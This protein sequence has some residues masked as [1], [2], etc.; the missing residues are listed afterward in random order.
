M[1]KK[2][3]I[4]GQL[5]PDGR[6]ELVKQWLAAAIL[7]IFVVGLGQPARA[8]GSIQINSVQPG[9]V[10]SLADRIACQTAI[11][12]IYWQHRIWPAENPGERPPFEKVVPAAAIEAKVMNSLTL[13]NGLAEMWQRPI[14]AEMLQA[15]VERQAEASQQ[16]EMLQEIWAALGNDPV[17]VAECLA[18]PVLATRLA[19]NWFAADERFSGRTFQAWWAASK[20][21]FVPE[22]TV[23]AGAYQLPAINRGRELLEDDTWRSTTATPDEQTG[24]AVWTGTEMLHLGN[25]STQGFRYNPATDTWDTMTTINA[26]NNVYQFTAVWT[27]TEMITWGGCN[28]GTEFCTTSLGGRYNPATDSWTETQFNGAPVGRRRHGAVWTGTEMIVW[29]GCRENSNGNQN[30]SIVLNNG[31][32]YN[33]N[34][35]SWQLMTTANAPAART[36]P[37]L[38][39]TDDEMILWSGTTF[40]ATAGSRY[41]PSTDSW[42]TMSTANAPSGR[43]APLVWTGSEV[44]AWGGCT[45][46]PFCDTAVGDGG[47]YNPDSDSWTPMSSSNAP[48]PRQEHGAVWTGSEM[49]VWGGNN[50]TTYYN[51]G[52]RYNPANDSWTTISTTNAPLGRAS[53]QY[54]WTGSELLV[55][56]GFGQ[57]SPALLRSGG[58]YNPSTNSWVAVRNEDPF[59]ARTLHRAIWTGVEMIAWGGYG[60]GTAASGLNTGRIYDPVTDSWDETSTANAPFG[61]AGHTAIWTGTEMIVWGGNTQSWSLPGDGGRYNPAT[62]SWTATSETNAPEAPS[63]HSAVWTGTEMIVWGGN[64][65][66]NPFDNEGGRY[67]PT[68]NSWTAMSDSNEPEGRYLHTAVWTGNVMVVWGGAGSTGT[69]GDGGVYNPTTNSWTAVSNT[70]APVDRV[71]HTAVWTGTEMII[72]GGSENYNEWPILNSG[73][74]YNPATNSWTPT[75]TAD[76]PTP[77]ARHTAVWTGDEMIVWG[78]CQPGDDCY[79]TTNTGGRYDPQ[80][81][82]WMLTTLEHVP[83]GRYFHTAVWTGNEMIVWGG[84]TED[85]GYA[86]TGGRYYAE[87]SGNNAPQANND[88]YGVVADGELVVNAPGVLANDSDLDSDPLTVALVEGPANGTLVLNGNGSFSYT[89]DAGYIGADS[90]SYQA[91]DGSMM[92]NVASVG[93]TVDGENSGPTATADVYMTNEDVPLVVAAPGVLANDQDVDGDG[94][95]AE[96][97]GNPAHGTVTLNGDGSFTY[98][99]DA[100]YH[101]ADSFTYQASDGII[102]SNVA[103]VS[104]TVNS[105]NDAPVAGNDGYTVAAGSTLDIGA[106]GVLGNDSDAE[107]NSLTVSLQSAPAHGEVT[108]NGNGSFSYTADDGYSGSDSF[109]YLVSDGQGGS[110]TATVTILVGVNHTIYLPMVV[111]P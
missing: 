3:R 17:L 110:D 87:T 27:G 6:L 30:C 11:E 47:R 63:Y 33:P 111:R 22:L 60:D 71:L 19:Q 5:L 49:I 9:Q 70:N 81:D 100:N 78:G 88:S 84:E 86:H 82:S 58:R 74:R 103:T 10:L 40:G 42:Q 92:S 66:D 36:Y 45:G 54:F 76:A 28:G 77:A 26:P 37:E 90:F 89:P 7:L 41:N 16:P 107:G 106:P 53:H 64:T 93:I 91:S 1:E 2:A 21:Q 72:W 62:D 68:T 34:T 56:G 31:G 25:F 38:I 102:E 67:N 52:R 104:L 20:E 44:I 12:R 75:N 39:W 59:S 24:E 23:P 98:T 79:D 94:L 108:L 99:P 35:D 97:V 48:S 8:A 105:M 43:Q 15:E 55:W 13:S 69:L 73:G 50:G 96:L 85:N 65:Y 18:R 14:T 51:D 101:G 95:T 83:D 80:A 61:R 57:G 29:G 46:S 32:R 109:T 4:T